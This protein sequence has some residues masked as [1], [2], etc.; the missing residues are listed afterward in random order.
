[1]QQ[2]ARLRL[3]PKAIVAAHD[4]IEMMGAES[5]QDHRGVFDRLVRGHGFSLLSEM[6][7]R[8]LYARIKH[9]AVQAM[10]EV[11][12]AEHAERIFKADSGV[13]SYRKAQQLFYAVAH[14]AKNLSERPLGQTQLLE[15]EVDRGR[16]VPLG[17]DERAIQ[18]EN[19]QVDRRLSHSPLYLAFLSSSCSTAR[20]SRLASSVSFIHASRTKLIIRFWPT[21]GGSTGSTMRQRFRMDLTRTRISSTDVSG[22]KP[23]VSKYTEPITWNVTGIIT[24]NR[25][26]TSH[27]R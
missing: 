3:Q 18:I 21:C 12:P 5:L 2:H 15:R 14:K 13:V 4:E 20:L 25:S 8:F 7:K 11:V 26:T 27:S 22:R 10:R 16:D 17:L 9:S 6:A 23:A 24:S 1:M 19:Q